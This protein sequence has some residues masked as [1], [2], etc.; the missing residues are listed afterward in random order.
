MKKTKKFIYPVIFSA[1]FLILYI[2]FVL[3]LT[4]VI[5]FPNGS[6][7]PAA[8]AVLFTFAWL[9]IALPIYCIRYSKIIVDEKL[10][11]LFP[12]YNSLLII[13]SHMLPFNLQGETRIIT[14]FV[15]WV[16]FWNMVPLICRLIS[17]KYEEK[18]AEKETQE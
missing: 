3:L 13:L 6:Y 12:V 2:S 4:T 7:A 11:F 9:I 14:H 16:L 8:L 17:R 5:S 1:L 10:K 15:L 18:D